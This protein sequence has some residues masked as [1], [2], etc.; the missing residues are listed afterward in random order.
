M[1]IFGS[2]TEHVNTETEV[3]VSL[4][5]NI[6]PT[7]ES[8]D[9]ILLEATEDLYKIR[10]GLYVAD[11]L[12]EEKICTE[13][14][15]EDI[16]A[17]TEATV[18]EAWDKVVKVFEDLWKNIQV[19]F[20]KALD[21]FNI[22]KKAQEKFIK[23]HGDEIKKKAAN[24][25]AMKGFEFS[26]YKYDVEAAT[27]V[28]KKAETIIKGQIDRA[29]SIDFEKTESV[30]N[31]QIAKDVAEYEELVC[32][33]IESG[34]KTVG[35]IKTAL[36]KKC[37]GDHNEKLTLNDISADQMIKFCTDTGIS[38]IKSSKK[39]IDGECKKVI[40]KFKKEANKAKKDAATATV[41]VNKVAP[42]YKKLI[43]INTAIN[44]LSVE[45]LKAANSQYMATLK[46]ILNYKPAA[47][48][49]STESILESAMSLLG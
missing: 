22:M 15:S 8:C 10:A 27:A 19:W 11:V 4:Y 23:D 26:G 1:A 49:E 18:K 35:E 40:D 25:D 24:A 43:A 16:E 17:V 45:M 5:P 39:F 34:T 28:A 37:K 12:I 44:S 46:K 20:Q 14:Y 2:R 32:S 3:D 29:N 6:H 21:F 36:L 7:M 9:S 33:M 41:G 38:N 48:K 42:N 47:A 13:G 31:L 30:E